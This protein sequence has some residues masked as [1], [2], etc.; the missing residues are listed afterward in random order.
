MAVGDF[1]VWSLFIAFAL[2]LNVHWRD[3]I[4]VDEVHWI[5]FL[6]FILVVHLNT[7]ASF[8]IRLD[9]LVLRNDI[10]PEMN[11][12]IG[13]PITTIQKLIIES[14]LS[15]SSKRLLD[16]ELSV[17]DVDNNGHAGSRR[18]FLLLA[19]IRETKLSMADYIFQREKTLP[20]IADTV[21]F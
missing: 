6:G 16:N 3:G 5:T 14:E 8:N 19:W 21:T 18:V 12:L 4:L 2:V 10:N 11:R 7:Y 20:S 1:I 17:A 13:V 9:S 15:D